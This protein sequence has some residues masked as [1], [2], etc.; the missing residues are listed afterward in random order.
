MKNAQGY[1]WYKNGVEITGSFSEPRY[2]VKVFRYL[3]I[4]NV[5]KSDSGVFVCVTSNNVGTTN[6]TVELLVEGISVVV[7]VVVIVVIVAVFFL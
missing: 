5:V 6:Y 1:S 7:V 3:E 4:T 2:T